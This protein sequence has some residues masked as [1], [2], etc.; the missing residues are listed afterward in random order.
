[1][2]IRQVVRPADDPLR[3]T[4][5]SHVS[6]ALAYEQNLQ[7]SVFAHHFSTECDCA[8]VEALFESKLRCAKDTRA[9]MKDSYIFLGR[10]SLDIPCPGCRIRGMDKQVIV[11][12]P[13]THN[14]GDIYKVT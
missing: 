10:H 11:S 4:P 12:P 6:W 7:R 13:H 1:M 14:L 9:T 8:F 3:A 5:T 2:E